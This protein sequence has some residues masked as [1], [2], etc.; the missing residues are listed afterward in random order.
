M[1]LTTVEILLRIAG[2]ALVGLIAAN[3][4]ATHRFAYAKNLTLASTIV[5]Q[6]FH[7]HCAYIIAII[8]GL[9]I[10]CLGW[11]H[12]LLDGPLARAVSGYFALFWASRVIVQ[13][14][15]YDPELR[16]NERSWDIFFLGVFLFLATT[17]TLATFITTP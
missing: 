13:L 17:F 11:P 12:L 5:R 6:I 14:T 4:V 15:Y 3:F 7:V 2:L 10:L 1:T 9:A 8:T 16:Q